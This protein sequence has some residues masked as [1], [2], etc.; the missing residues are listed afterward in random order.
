MAKMILST[1]GE[2]FLH[3]T[4]YKWM[5]LGAA[6]HINNRVYG[7]HVEMLEEI[8]KCGFKIVI[9]APSKDYLSTHTP[10]EIYQTDVPQAPE[11]CKTIW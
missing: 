9:N 10:I 8:E 2:V 1:I 7:S 6:T 4:K 5:T 11:Q 3:L